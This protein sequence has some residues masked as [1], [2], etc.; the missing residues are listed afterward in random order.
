[1][2][3]DPAITKPKKTIII[4]DG[5]E[6]SFKDAALTAANMNGRIP[7][8]NEFESALREYELFKQAIDYTFWCVDNHGQTLAV[9]VTGFGMG[10]ASLVVKEGATKARIA[11]LKEDE[12][13]FPDDSFRP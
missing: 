2:E 3:R 7:R 9:T 13:A 1:M 11:V 12:Y 10:A 6:V 4:V 8:R 5:G